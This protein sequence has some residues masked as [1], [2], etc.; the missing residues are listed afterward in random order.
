[1]SDCINLTYLYCE[2]NQLTSPDVSKND[3][4]VIESCD[5][6]VS[7]MG[8][9]DSNEQDMEALEN[10]IAKQK[11]L[12]V[13]TS[14]MSYAT[15]WTV[16][17]RLVG[18]YWIDRELK[19]TISFSA[20]TALRDL[21]CG[22]NQLTSLDVSNCVNLE[23]LDCSK[24]RLTSLD[25]SKNLNLGYLYCRGNQISRLDLTNNTVL[26]FLGCD[27]TVTVIGSKV[28]ISEDDE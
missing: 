12:G 7:I 14:D 10:L 15:K 25:V 11:E 28:T 27:T 5:K 16:K 8:G 20:F 19:G 9:E 6:S 21:Q 4:L 23:V 1:M 22:N 24:N 17:G 18:I 26:E 13:D 3:I 2:G